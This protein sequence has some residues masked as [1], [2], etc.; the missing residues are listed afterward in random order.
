M[1]ALAGNAAV[2]TGQRGATL[3][4]R[5]AVAEQPST[6]AAVAADRT[7]ST[8]ASGSA[9]ANQSGRAAVAAH[10]SRQPV[11]PAAAVA[12][13]QSAGPAVT[14]GCAGGAVADQR[15]A[16]QRLGG[17]IHHA[18]QKLVSAGGLGTGIR[19]GTGIECLHELCVKYGALRADGLIGLRVPTEHGR[20]RRRYFV[21]RCNQHLSRRGESRCVGRPERGADAGEIRCCGG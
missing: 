18:Q 16:Q 2:D 3:T 1:A 11:A 5:A 6:A 12:E 19:Q 21:G 9:A 20:D 17:R 4:T 15:A 10:L 13:Q 8:G 14:A 7:G